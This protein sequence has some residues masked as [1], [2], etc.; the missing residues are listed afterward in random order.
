MILLLDIESTGLKPGVDRVVELG[1]M[2]TSEDY[3]VVHNKYSKL[4]WDDTYPEMLPEVTAVNGITTDMLKGNSIPP[5]VACAD[6]EALMYSYGVRYIIAYNA[7]FDKEFISREMQVVG[8]TKYQDYKWLCAMADVRANMK[9]SSWKLMHVALDHGVTVNPK[10]LHR[11]IN[12]VELMRQMLV[13]ADARPT[14]MY[15]YQQSPNVY[16][17]A[18]V[19]KP[20]DDDGLSTQQAKKLG[21]SW[22]KA[23]GDS[24]IFQKTWVKRI[25]ECD[26]L[27]QQA[28]FPFI[29]TIL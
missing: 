11:A 19:K 4:I 2:V 27:E 22:E 25:K 1:M 6:I 17:Q 24:R 12:D 20:W 18:H 21:F 3:T 8:K 16:V 5:W 7:Q 26:L 13:A 9:C 14:E 15:A 28:T 10:E 29:T 23:R